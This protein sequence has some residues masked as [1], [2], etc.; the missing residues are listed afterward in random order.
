MQTDDA[1]SLGWCKDQ[2]K[3]DYIYYC[4]QISPHNKNYAMRKVSKFGKMRTR[5]KS[6]LGLFSLFMQWKLTV[7]KY[8]KKC[9]RYFTF[10]VKKAFA[11]K[12]EP[13][14]K[15]WTNIGRKASAFRYFGSPTRPF[16]LL[17]R[18]QIGHICVM[19]TFA[20]PHCWK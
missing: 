19:V 12:T 15:M 7:T 5:K 4:K 17:W 10:L 20:M 14:I 16:I 9:L 13:I 8:L 1:Y 3:N 2:M 18:C 11:L 6:V